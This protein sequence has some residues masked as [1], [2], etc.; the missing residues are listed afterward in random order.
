MVGRWALFHI[1]G[2]GFE[3]EEGGRGIQ[4][5]LKESSKFPNDSNSGEGVSIQ[6]EF[7]PSRSR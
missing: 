2:G 1:E 4:E 6:A 5:L 7:A 3:V